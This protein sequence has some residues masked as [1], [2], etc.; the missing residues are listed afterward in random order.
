MIGGRVALQLQPH[1]LEHLAAHRLV[2]LVTGTNGKT[3]TTRMLSE[4][5]CAGG[6]SVAS[7][8]GG[9]NMTPGVVTALMSNLHAGVAI[10][11]IDE[12]HLELIAKATCPRVIVLLNLSRDQLDRVG[13]IAVIEKRIRSAVDDNPQAYVV[14]NV[15]DP[16][17]TSAAWDS[18][19]PVWVA[20]GK[21]WSG[22]S[23][24]APR[25]GGAI[26][27]SEDPLG[28]SDDKAGGLASGRDR[29]VL[30]RSVP[31]EELLAREV[32]WG[33]GANQSGF[34]RPRPKWIWKAESFHA[35]APVQLVDISSG[36]ET[37]ATVQLPGRANRGNALQAFVAARL[38]GVEA[39]DAA[40]GIAKV[41]DVAGRYASFSVRGRHLR[42]LL[43]KNPAGWMESLTMLNP[44]AAIIVGVNGQ[45][46]DGTDLSWLWDVNF[47]A[48]SGKTVIA[49]GERGADLQVRLNYA[50][51]ETRWA[52][53]VLEAIEMAEP[54]EVDMLL[55]YTS[56]RDARA[57]FV[58]Q[59]WL[60]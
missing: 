46:A 31:V 10:L 23:L 60:R 8:R 19:H 6:V 39:N 42:M 3:T 54:G 28:G 15:D 12:M 2:A 5:V 59:G 9:D 58:A 51:I 38:L 30:W 32:P 24:T 1:I 48:L 20:A 41:K 36:Q 49:T 34:A 40:A 33:R 55:N 16:L 57:E 44:Q 13:E 25:T 22:D 29:N 45:I 21:G 47:E 50:G 4:A 35:G 7:N 14:A 11:E 53:T 18:A 27:Y 56:F 52:P 17:M 37:T 43:A 26:I